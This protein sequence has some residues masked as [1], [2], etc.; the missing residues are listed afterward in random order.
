MGALH[1]ATARAGTA[2]GAVTLGTQSLGRTAESLRAQ[3]Q[4]FL[5]QLDTGAGAA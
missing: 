5:R 1:A 2:V 3:V 4:G